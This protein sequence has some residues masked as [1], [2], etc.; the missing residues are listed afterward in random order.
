MV[1]PAQTTPHLCT[2]LGNAVFRPEKKE[3]EGQRIMIRSVEMH[4]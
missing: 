3:I 2:Y 1:Y 4:T